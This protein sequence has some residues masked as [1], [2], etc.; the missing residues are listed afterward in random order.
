M[1][2]C[3]KSKNE[4]I[5]SPINSPIQINDEPIQGKSISLRSQLKV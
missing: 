1:G 4:K 3:L 5:K 2:N